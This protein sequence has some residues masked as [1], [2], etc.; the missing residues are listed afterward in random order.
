MGHTLCTN[1]CGTCELANLRI[2]EPEMTETL[3][4]Q[5]IADAMSLDTLK[6]FHPEI[7]MAAV[8]D[9][10]RVEKRYQSE[11]IRRANTTPSTNGLRQGNRATVS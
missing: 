9:G 6:R 4:N 3:D 5:T 1:P 8:R 10:I 11:R 2:C 7:Y